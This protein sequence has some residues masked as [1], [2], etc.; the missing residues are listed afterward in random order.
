MPD[1]DRDAL[2]LD[3]RLQADPEL[4][5]SA[6]R[7][8][9]W[10]IVLTV[11]LA[12]AIVVVTFYGLTHHR[13][14][15]QTAGAPASETTGAVP[16]ATQQD[17]NNQAAGQAGQQAQ[18]GQAPAGQS[19]GQQSPSGTQAQGTQQD[20]AD[21]SGQQGAPG[22]QANQKSSGGPAAPPQTTGS[23]PSDANA[24]C[25]VPPTPSSKGQPAQQK[26]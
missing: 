23:A 10:Q 17:S 24:P 25:S 26:K 11:I 19:A 1:P 7:V 5:T 3:R 22:G 16:P 6:G 20:Q 18:Q 15:T 9:G 2:E 12:I 8:R 21:P 4:D 13:V 14:E